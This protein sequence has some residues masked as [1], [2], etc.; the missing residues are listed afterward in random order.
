[1]LLKKR[2][3][4]FALLEDI[5]R[6][7]WS[8]ICYNT[9]ESSSYQIRSTRTGDQFAYK[10]N[11]R[12]FLIYN[13]DPDSVGLF[14]CLDI[15]QNKPQLYMERITHP[16]IF[17]DLSD[18][19]LAE[20]TDYTE[21]TPSIKFASK[22]NISQETKRFEY[23]KRMDYGMVVRLPKIPAAFGSSLFYWP[24][25]YDSITGNAPRISVKQ[26]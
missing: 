21:I 4:V 11:S 16:Q 5:V 10:V 2:V 12:I 20:R 13:M 18:A 3:F 22:I 23:F 1:M 6:E 14:L 7:H 15:S 8:M 17:F 19:Q 9:D 25:K 26:T 24:V